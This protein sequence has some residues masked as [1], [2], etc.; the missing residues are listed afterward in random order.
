MS[1]NHK[2][3]KNIE[4]DIITEDA[5]EVM[6]LLEKDPNLSQR[7][8]AKKSGFSIGKVN[9]CL[10]AL[11]DVGF[12][13]LHNFSKSSKKLKYAYIITPRGI[14]EKIIITKRFIDKKQIEYDKLVSFLNK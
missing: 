5:L 4:G 14:K 13:K 6:H 2:T 1:K 12:I 11:V 8:L 10:K 3:S 7:L 9:Y